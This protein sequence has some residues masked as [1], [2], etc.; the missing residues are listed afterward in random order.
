VEAL[1]CGVRYKGRFYVGKRV[2]A[3]FFVVLELFGVM[4]ILSVA[5]GF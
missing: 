2:Q 3:L 1:I 4:T 5:S